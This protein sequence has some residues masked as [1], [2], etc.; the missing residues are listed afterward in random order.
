MNYEELLESRQGEHPRGVKTP[1]GSLARKQIDGQWR[2]EMRLDP[3][4]AEDPLFVSAL[5]KDEEA[6]RLINRP[7]QA[8][9]TIERD[10][11]GPYALLLDKGN[12]TTLEQYISEQPMALARKGYVE[13]TLQRMVTL[14]DTAAKQGLHMV[15]MHPS[16][17]LVRRKEG[18]VLA[19]LHG[20]LYVGQGETTERVFGS[21]KE[22][23]APEVLDGAQPDAKSDTY[24]LAWLAQWL[25]QS[26]EAPFGAKALLKK[27]LSPQPDKR[28][29]KP[30]T[31]VDGIGRRKEAA[32]QGVILLVATLIA[33]IAIGFYFEM[34]PETEV[35][36][37]V[38]PNGVDTMAWVLEDTIFIPD[39]NLKPGQD[40]MAALLTPQERAMMKRYEK[41]AEEIFR[42][43]F[44]K[45]AD[46]ILSN[47]YSSKS[48]ASDQ[49]KFATISI[50]GAEQL[51]QLEKDLANEV[52]ITDVRGQKL[53]SEVIQEISKKKLDGLKGQ[54]S[55]T[56]S[57]KEE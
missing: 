7:E 36:E 55:G 41:K 37:F 21:V 16:L 28:P 11:A 1:I 51:D 15:S 14:C 9:F 19:L 52:G 57:S 3:Q 47:I 39:D 13:T 40:T 10:S 24:A 12:Y 5:E 32:K 6:T 33:A 26:A 56:T 25:Y 23:I 43:R 27:A 49:E 53:A 45:A 4:L 48:M 18:E 20:S 34:V 22:S 30:Q 2:Y 35:V 38:K 31:L 17:L 46:P 29:D 8:K 54:G 44:A 50:T 42:K